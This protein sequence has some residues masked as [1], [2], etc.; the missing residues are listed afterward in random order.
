MKRDVQILK[1]EIQD[2]KQSR[3]KVTNKLFE[4][5]TDEIS[6][7]KLQILHLSDT[8]SEIMIKIVNMET[9]TDETDESKPVQQFWHKSK[10][11]QC[12][13][14]F[15]KKRTLRN[16]INTKHLEDDSP[17]ESV[18]DLEYSHCEEKI[19]S[20]EE[21]RDHIEEHLEEIKQID[22]EYLLVISALSTQMTLRRSKSTYQTISE[23]I[24]HVLDQMKHT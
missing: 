4:M 17:E 1:A 7:L 10:F 20:T 15:N 6:K 3:E 14:K 16:Y 2:L 22:I 24:I 9:E 8:M 23:M 18:S 13:Y 5:Q 11:D 21:L 12:Q 19:N